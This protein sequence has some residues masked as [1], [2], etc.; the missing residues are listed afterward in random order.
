MIKRN[1]KCGSTN[2][3]TYGTHERSLPNAFDGGATHYGP[4]KEIELKVLEPSKY[5]KIHIKYI[6]TTIL[7]RHIG[8]Y[9][10]F[11][12]RMP[13]EIVNSST[14]DEQPE[15]CVDGCPKLQQIDY[16]KFLAR[17]Q[18]KLREYERDNKVDMS[19]VEAEAACRNANVAGFYF[20]S[21]VFDLMTTGDNNFTAAAYNAWQDLLKLNPEIAKNGRNRTDLTIYDDR[22]SGISPLGATTF[23]NLLVLSCTLLTIWLHSHNNMLLALRRLRRRGLQLIRSTEEPARE[24]NVQVAEHSTDTCTLNVV[25][26]DIQCD[27]VLQG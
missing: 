14:A 13:E 3:L 24:I 2:V 10:T 4:G 26:G 15:L 8:R 7:V 27:T 17:R 23:T 18:E 19:R 11:S 12:I 22:Y 5:V 25:L 21:C 6:D 9:F 1:D 16:K 20:D